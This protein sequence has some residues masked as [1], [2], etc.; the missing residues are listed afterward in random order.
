VGHGVHGEVELNVPLLLAV[1]PLDPASGLLHA[2]AGGVDGDGDGL[3]GVF[4]ILVRVDAEE[5]DAFPDAGVV[6]L[7][8]VRD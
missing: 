4:E 5:E 8:E 1:L 3:G 6:G 2:Y 7:W